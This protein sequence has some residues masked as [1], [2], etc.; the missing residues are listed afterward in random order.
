[1][2]DVVRE[3]GDAGKKMVWLCAGCSKKYVVQTWREAGQQIRP[4]QPRP[5]L[6]LDDILSV[7]VSAVMPKDVTV[8]ASGNVAA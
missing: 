1:M 4:R 7:H 3:C 6:Q 5:L 2:I 8:T